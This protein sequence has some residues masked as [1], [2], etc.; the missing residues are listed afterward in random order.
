[1]FSIFDCVEYSED[2]PTFLKLTVD[3]FSPLKNRIY[4]RKGDNIGGF[5]K[6]ANGEPKCVDFKY[7]GKKVP[8]AQH[9][10]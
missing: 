4:A 6:R 1:M 2:S 3:N 5:R 9:S 8:C 7:H 10:V